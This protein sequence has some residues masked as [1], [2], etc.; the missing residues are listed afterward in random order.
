MTWI[1]FRRSLRWSALA[2][3]T[4]RIFMP[5]VLASSLWPLAEAKPGAII[6]LCL[7]NWPPCSKHAVWMMNLFLTTPTSSGPSMVLLMPLTGSFG[8]HLIQWNGP[9]HPAGHLSISPCSVL[10]ATW[11]MTMRPFGLKLKPR[12]MLPGVACIS[13]L[14]VLW[15]AE[16]NN[17]IR[18]CVMDNL[19][20]R[21]QV[22]PVIVSLR[23]LVRA[24]SMPSG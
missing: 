22:V 12:T 10:D 13:L 23:S 1:V 8:R 2:F 17:G 6:C 5:S 7:V 15:V 3:V 18:N 11:R 9:R 19:P 4:S 14:S 24:S 21:K 16:A 20:P